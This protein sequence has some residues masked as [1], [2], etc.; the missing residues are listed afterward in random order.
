MSWQNAWNLAKSDYIKLV[1]ILVLA[2]YITFIPHIDYPYP[3]HV[4]EWRHIAHNNA[5]IQAAD[6]DYPDPFSGRTLAGGERIVAELEVGFHIFI[7]VFHR[8]SGIS[9]ADIHRYF[10]SII[11][12]MT[13]LSVYILAKR[14]GFGLEAA[15]FTCLIIT[16]VGIL[17]PAFLV[18]VAVGLYFL[19]LY[20]FIAFNFRTGW[21]YLV[22]SIFTCFL[23][24]MHA[25]SAICI[26]IVLVPFIL[27]TLRDNFRHSLGLILAIAVPFL[28]TLPWTS[29]LILSTSKWLFMPQPLPANRDYPQLV[30]EYG[31]LPFLSCLLGSFALFL[32]G[33]KENNSLAMGLLALSLMLAFFYTLHYGIAMLYFRGLQY[34]MLI[35]SIVAGAGLMELRKLELQVMRG[36]RVKRPIIVK[37]VGMLLCLVFI[38]ATL[39]I[40]IPDRQAMP[41]YHMIDSAD[42]EAFT[43]IRDNIGEDY[44]KA[45]LDP[46]KATAFTAI[47]GK[48]VHTKIHA[49][50][51]RKSREV[52]AYLDSG[53]IDTT[54]LRENG[55]SIIYYQKSCLNPDLV[56]VRDN[57]YLLE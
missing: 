24:T 12:M 5:L 8:L 17:G 18:P 55:I 47:T 50:L 9:W 35:M 30:Q 33:N 41:Y 37:V 21:C 19:P 3:V 39:A 53:C 31:Y 51:T 57:I 7:A 23:V 11:F 6:I 14:K 54:F 20:L 15:F 1:P 56:E 2:F 44:E 13:V 25:P 32:R 36:L 46:W 52:Y 29:S 4:D 22:L 10:P 49:S 27:F 40:G 45:I 34:V 26:V 42:Y 16:T 48:Y 43:W 28:V 38:G